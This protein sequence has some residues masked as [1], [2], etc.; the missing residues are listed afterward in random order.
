MATESGCEEFEDVI[1]QADLAGKVQS[2]RTASSVYPLQVTVG[3]FPQ[4]RLEPSASQGADDPKL[5]F[6]LCG[7]R[8]HG[9]SQ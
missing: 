7:R 5:M 1:L 3:F 4:H 6:S 2:P 8:S 9:R